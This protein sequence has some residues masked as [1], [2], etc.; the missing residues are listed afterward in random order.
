[1]AWN[2]FKTDQSW[3]IEAEWHT[4][5]LLTQSIIGCLFSAKPLFEPMLPYC[6]LDRK[7]HISVKL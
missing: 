4:Y 6:Q 1:M 5:A 2:L 3:L 7:E